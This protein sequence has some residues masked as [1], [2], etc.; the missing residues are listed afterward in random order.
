MACL[1][2]YRLLLSNVTP[3]CL[4]LYLIVENDN[5]G[6]VVCFGIAVLGLA[7]GDVTLSQWE[8]RVQLDSW[9]DLDNN[10]SC[11]SS[12]SMRHA[13]R[14]G[15]KQEQILKWNKPIKILLYSLACFSR[16]CGWDSHFFS[17]S[18][19]MLWAESYIVCVFSPLSAH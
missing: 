9:I 1:G 18:L 4:F 8:R 12:S 2:T 14:Q 7:Q 6:L 17:P 15:K 10:A 5:E 3:V 13:A 11:G 19:F 16:F